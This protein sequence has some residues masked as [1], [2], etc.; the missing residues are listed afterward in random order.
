MK[1]KFI[2]INLVLFIVLSAQLHSQDCSLDSTGLIPITDLGSGYYEGFQG[3]L[4]YGSN[5]KPVVQIENLNYGISNISPRNTYGD[6]DINNG[7]IVLLSIG[8]SNPRTE[9]ESF[10]NITDTFCLI[11]PFLKIVN[12]GEGG[13][14]IQK[15]IDT[16]NYYWQYVTD[17]LISNGVNNNQV[18]IIWLENDNSSS[19]N[20]NFPSAPQELMIE[21]KQLFKILID[22]Y[23]NLQ[24]CYLNGRGYGGYIESDSQV[25]NGLRFPRDYYNGWAMKWLIENQIMGDTSLAF[26]GTNRNAPVLD[27]SAYLWTDGA[28]PRSD[29][30]YTE[31]STDL[32]PADGL[33]WSPAG[34]DKLGME[35]FERFYNDAEARKWFLKDSATI[36]YD[37]NKSS[38]F[39]FYPNPSDDLFYIRSNC[40][41]RFDVYM[42]SAIGELVKEEKNLINNP[43]IKS[44]LPQGVYL[45]VIKT[46]TN[47]EF[48]YKM[49]IRR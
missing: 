3:G 17:Q 22:K 38:Y 43:I 10:Q 48:S 15:I 33:H 16:S 36:S 7:N 37:E 18:Q 47:D 29:G 11:N 45:L 31:C 4:Y 27:W 12:G 42:Y 39:K 8:A 19:E 26:I 24:V 34:N 9:F 25:G 20:Y 41:E 30:L 5:E 28:N 14:A 46:E 1:N 6:Y 35:I 13:Q 21:F 2:F 49:I 23:P 32:K 44:D 40:S